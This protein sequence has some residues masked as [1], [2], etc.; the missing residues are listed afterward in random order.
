MKLAHLDGW[1]EARRGTR[2]V[3]ASCSPEAAS[4]YPV[5]AAGCRHVY[6]VFAIEVAG[7]DRVRDRL[8]RAGIA[9]RHPL[10]DARP[11]AA[12]LSRT[13]AIGAGD[14]PVAERFAAATLSL[15]LYPELQPH[16]IERIADTL[17][18]V[19]PSHHA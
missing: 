10:P 5:E 12:G 19:E 17:L 15:P 3:T 1:T 16:Q 4:G 14:F 18:A 8:A 13:S 2:R 6:H 9:H 7:R 11:S